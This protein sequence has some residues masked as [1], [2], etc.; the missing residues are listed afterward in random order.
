MLVQGV[1]EQVVNWAGDVSDIVRGK[2]LMDF[3]VPLSIASVGGVWGD[4]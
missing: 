4:V 3:F 1:Q 2:Q